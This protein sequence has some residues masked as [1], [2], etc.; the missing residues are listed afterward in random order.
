MPCRGKMWASPIP[1]KNVFPLTP[2]HP[3]GPW[4][5]RLLSLRWSHTS[6]LPTQGKSLPFSGSHLLMSKMAPTIPTLP[7][8]RRTVCIKLLVAPHGVFWRDTCA[9]PDVTPGRLWRCGHPHRCA[10]F[11]SFYAHE[12]PSLYLTQRGWRNE[13]E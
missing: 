11:V 2:S 6:A 8:A 7:R 1:P 10:A 3:G 9:F 5:R 4:L 12:A 13:I